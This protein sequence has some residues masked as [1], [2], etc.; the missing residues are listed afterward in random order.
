[1]M[2]HAATDNEIEELPEFH[3]GWIA[4][5]KFNVIFSTRF[6]CMARSGDRSR[7]YIGPE[8]FARRAN[9]I[10]REERNL[11]RP[12]AY[13]KD[14]HSRRH[15][16]SVKA[17]TS[18]W[19]KKLCLPGEPL[20]FEIGVAKHIFGIIHGKHPKCS[21]GLRQTATRIP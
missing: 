11:A 6:S 3:F 7:R 8:H 15:A 12:A 16:C 14:T 21:T 17:I 10:S 20:K 18:R 2:K 13:V 19:F 1:M 5:T 4:M 9:E